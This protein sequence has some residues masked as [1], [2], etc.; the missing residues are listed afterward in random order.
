MQLTNPTRA[1]KKLISDRGLDPVEWQVVTETKESLIVRHR[2]T[3][4]QRLL[5][6]TYAKRSWMR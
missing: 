1:Q 6:R 5:E 2:E 3:G 4:E